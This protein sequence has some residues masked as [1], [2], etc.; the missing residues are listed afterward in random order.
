MTKIRLTNVVDAGN[1]EQ[2]ILGPALVRAVELDALVD[3]GATL[4]ALPEGAVAALGLRT[5]APLPVRLA[6]GT[7]REVP[8]AYGIWIEI[9]NRGMTCDALVMPAGTTPLIGQLQ[10]EGLDLL[11]DPKSQNVMVNPASPDTPM[12]DLLRAS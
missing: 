6:D 3:T 7:V 12:F 11:I 8:M 9:L 4:L 5:G 10:L 2:G 1:A